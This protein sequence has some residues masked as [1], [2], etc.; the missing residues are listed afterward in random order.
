MYAYLTNL[1]NMVDIKLKIV[2]FTL[3]VMVL[4]LNGLSLLALLQTR[5]TPK[6][7]RFL[8][9]ALLGFDFLST[10]LYT[11]RKLVKDAKYNIL[12]QQIALGCSYS[13][14]INIAIMSLE[15]L[16]LFEWPIFYLRY[17]RFFWVKVF[18]VAILGIYLT[19]YSIESTLCYVNVNI[20][21]V[22]TLFCFEKVIIQH[23]LVA[24]TITTLV[25]CTALGRILVI[26]KRQQNKDIRMNGNLK[27]NLRNHKSTLCVLF[28]CGNY[29]VTTFTCML[30]AFVV[31]QNHLR[32]IVIDCVLTV[33]CL[34]DTC[35]YVLWFKECRLKLMQMLAMVCPALDM[36]AEKMRRHV[37]EIMTYDQKSPN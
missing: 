34:V 12:L 10:L 35:V 37:F 3:S 23:A 25:S 4:V 22:E 33:N 5:H 24:F 18:C 6:R 16:L 31:K 30:L 29:L 11:T 9:A 20:E 27:C 1:D 17:V 36:K 21:D 7:A 8:S 15:R 2:I 13:V 32:R 19:I 14:Y 26:I 28:C